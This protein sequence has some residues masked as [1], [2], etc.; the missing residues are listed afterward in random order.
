[1]KTIVALF[2]SVRPL[3]GCIVVL[4]LLS[5][6]IGLVLRIGYWGIHLTCGHVCR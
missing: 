5:L 6:A 2:E 1:M 3:L 4:F